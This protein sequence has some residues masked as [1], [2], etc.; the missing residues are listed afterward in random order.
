MELRTRI[1]IGLKLASEYHALGC[2]Q[3]RENWAYYR[4]PLQSTSCLVAKH[5]L[6]GVSVQITWSQAD[7]RSVLAVGFP[8]VRFRM[9]GKSVE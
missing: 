3:C 4:Y 9:M 6:F 8:R 7:G 2:A 5:F 1:D